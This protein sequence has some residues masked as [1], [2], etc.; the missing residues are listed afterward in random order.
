[1]SVTIESAA[2]VGIP[3]SI[4]SSGRPRSGIVIH[5]VGGNSITRGSHTACRQQVRNW[6]NY[7]R[8]G[9]GWA[10]IGYHYCLCHHGIVM[11]G[12]GLNR[13]GAHAPGANSTH[14]GVLFMLGGSQEPTN[15]Q[16]AGFRAF[17]TWLGRQGVNQSSVTPHSRWISTSCPGSHLRSRISGNNWGAGGTPGG[18]GTGGTGN[19]NTAPTTEG[20]DEMLGLKRGA[21]GQAVRSLQVY[22]RDCGYPPKNSMRKDGEYD[23]VYGDGVASAVLK[24]RKDQGSNVKSGDHISYWARNQMRRAWFQAQMKATK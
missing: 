15:D 11:T 20:D 16:L 21:T 19:D 3:S 4:G 7:H 6:H 18:P 12:R 22:L 24:L 23:G 14:V 8:T 10:G 13:V 17:R 1:M 5:Y 2:T 9:Q